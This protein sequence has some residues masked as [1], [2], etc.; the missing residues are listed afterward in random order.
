MDNV[1]MSQCENLKIEY[2]TDSKLNT[3][4]FIWYSDKIEF[5][6]LGTDESSSDEWQMINHSYKVL[7]YGRS[8]SKDQV[9]VIWRPEMQNCTFH[10]RH[11]SVEIIAKSDQKRPTLIKNFVNT[12]QVLQPQKSI[13]FEKIY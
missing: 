9:E 1:K 11:L 10:L 4:L 2:K 12:E 6:I 3:K 13:I 7:F 5:E 8:R